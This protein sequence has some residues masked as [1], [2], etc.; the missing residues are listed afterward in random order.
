MRILTVEDEANI[1]GLIRL[2]L[3]QAGYRCVCCQDGETAA[4]LLQENDYDLVLLDIMLPGH[5]GYTLLEYIR[6]LGMPVIFL[7]ARAAVKDRVKGLKLGADDY[8]VKPFEPE[9]LLARIEAVLR[10]A[11]KGD[12][13]VSAHDAVLH[14]AARRVTQNGREVALTCHEYDLL[15]MLV[16]NRG[17]ALYRDALF[18]EVW[19]AE[20]PEGSRTLDLHIMRLRHKLGWQNKIKTVYKIG[21]ML[22]REP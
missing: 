8:I 20:A 22:E 5:D 11:G 18:E 1:S 6:P 2:T 15:L 19:G 17:T 13:E 9:E 3:Q 12:C 10:R 7:T 16:R 14:L 21:Y 4:D